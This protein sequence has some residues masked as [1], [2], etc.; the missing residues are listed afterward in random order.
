M[1][2]GRVSKIKSYTQLQDL[3]AEKSDEPEFQDQFFKVYSIYPDISLPD[4]HEQIYHFLTDLQFGLPVHLARNE[5]KSCSTTIQNGVTESIPRATNTKSFR[6]NVGNPFPGPNYQKAQHC[7]DLIYIYNSFAE[8]LRAV[9]EQLPADVVKNQNLVDSFQ[10]D[11]IRFIADPVDATEDGRATYYNA[12]RTTHVVDVDSD[13]RWSERRVR[14][15]FLNT[16][17]LSSQ[18]ALEAFSGEGHSF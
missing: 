2:A 6:V 18:Q 9:D 15:E 4:L 13:E 5:L 12:D 17:T 3:L 16:F 7:V 8:A 11:W 1:H 10:E 14:Y